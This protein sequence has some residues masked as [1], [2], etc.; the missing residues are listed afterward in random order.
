MTP[1][2]LLLLCSLGL[3]LAACET[4]GPAEPAPNIAD[5]LSL[6]TPEGQKPTTAA[7]H[8][9]EGSKLLAKGLY[10]LAEVEFRKSVEM[11]GR[12]A[13]AW[14]GLAASY[15]NLR[16]FDLA[17]RAYV[18][19]RKILGPTAEVINNE[20]YSQLMRGNIRKARAMFEQAH[21]MDPANPVINRNLAKVNEAQGMKLP[22]EL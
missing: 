3:P 21:T 16:R 9:A 2:R 14:L 19:V 20:G 6:V 8:E 12:S 18:Q 17:D 4:F 13:Q 10:G 15:D 11:N 7:E 5:Q 22:P 1:F